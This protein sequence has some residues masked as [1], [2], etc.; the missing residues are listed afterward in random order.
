M[1]WVKQHVFK[2]R[3]TN[4]LKKLL[5][6]IE[7]KMKQGTKCWHNYISQCW[8]TNITELGQTRSDKKAKLCLERPKSI[9]SIGPVS[10]ERVLSH[11]G[12]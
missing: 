2:A 5:E 7:K 11:F 10:G 1:L 12:F 3:W 4:V 9:F 8:F 6:R